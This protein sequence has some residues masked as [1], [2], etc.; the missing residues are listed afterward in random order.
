MKRILTIA[1]LI[2]LFASG[3]MAASVEVSDLPNMS[4]TVA[5][6]WYV[7]C[8]NETATGRCTI[9]SIL[10]L[11]STGLTDPNAHRIAG[12]DNTDNLWSWY[13]IGSGL[14]YDHATHTLTATSGGNA[15][16][17]G[18]TKGVVTFPATAGFTC[19][20]GLCSLDYTTMQVGSGS[21]P[22]ILSTTLYNTFN[23]KQAALT[24]PFEGPTDAG[25]MTG[26]MLVFGA[27][28]DGKW[29]VTDGGALFSPA[30]PGAIGGSTPAVGTFTKVE[31]TANTAATTGI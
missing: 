5:T 18:A 28:A 26:H 14:S 17:D 11:S 4:S 10:G 27:Y 23:G 7:V 31:V 21:V 25:G 16:D 22:G 15:D 12:W 30:S 1:L 2:L 24:R 29:T 8:D 6:T 13:T 3:L 9:S 19:T 20:L